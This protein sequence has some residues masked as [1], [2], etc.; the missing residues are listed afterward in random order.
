MPEPNTQDVQTVNEQCRSRA[1]LVATAAPGNRFVATAEKNKSWKM[2]P[3]RNSP[4][5]LFLGISQIFA[6][7]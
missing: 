5:S 7:F 3:G 4:D 2:I 6:P 1:F